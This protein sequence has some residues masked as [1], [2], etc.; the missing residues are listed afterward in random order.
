MLPSLVA[1]VSPSSKENHVTVH[2]TE[3]FLLRGNS[4][5]LAQFNYQLC[6]QNSLIQMCWTKRHWKAHLVDSYSSESQVKL[7][8]IFISRVTQDG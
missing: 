5:K 2:S 1:R 6:L 3:L 8:E 4:N 7:D